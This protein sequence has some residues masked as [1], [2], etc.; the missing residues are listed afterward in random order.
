MEHG[1]GL[2]LVE[3]QFLLILSRSEGKKQR[4]RELSR[5]LAVTQSRISRLMDSLVEKGYTRRELTRQDRRATFAVLTETG[6]VVC[7][8]K[9]TSFV[10][11]LYQHFYGPIEQD[12][13]VFAGFLRKL[14]DPD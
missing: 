6:Q 13:E 7:D 2:S 1:L 12:A 8:Q 3:Y 4:F 14:Y 5:S 10:E 9:F 11:T